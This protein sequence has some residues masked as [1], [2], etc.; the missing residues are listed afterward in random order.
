MRGGEG[1]AMQMLLIPMREANV[2]VRHTASLR[3]ESRRP[4]EHQPRTLDVYRGRPSLTYVTHLPT[5]PQSLRV[6]NKL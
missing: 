6:V 5:T 3:D 1:G 2:Q 4:G